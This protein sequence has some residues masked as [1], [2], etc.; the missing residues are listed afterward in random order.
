LAYIKHL[1][2]IIINNLRSDKLEKYA[3]SLELGKY[4]NKK[5]FLLKGPF[6]L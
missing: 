1:N 3:M 5:A 4:A 2:L 6:G